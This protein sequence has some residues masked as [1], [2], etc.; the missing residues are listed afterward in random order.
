[1]QRL[2]KTSMFSSS[3]EGLIHNLGV[4]R[5]IFA[6]YSRGFCLSHRF[7]HG[8]SG[9]FC[10]SRWNTLYKLIVLRHLCILFK[11][12]G[13]SADFQVLLGF[14]HSQAWMFALLRITPGTAG[15][16]HELSTTVGR[17]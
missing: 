13:H 1:M 14:D 4:R 12:A 2:Q 16:I 6:L 9:R 10:E 8:K 7:Y 5:A 17:A 11:N 15:F 3:L